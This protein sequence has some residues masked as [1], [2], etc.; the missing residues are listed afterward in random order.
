M[1]EFIDY[2]TFSKFGVDVLLLDASKAFD[3]GNYY[4]L[5]NELLK[6]NISPVLLRLLLYNMYT[7]QSLR[8]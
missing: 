4:N 1:L 5:F 7:T 6:R 8:V 3:R 2:Y